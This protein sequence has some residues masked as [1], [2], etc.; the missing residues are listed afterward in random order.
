MQNTKKILLT[1]LLA[2][3]CLT[4]AASF[5]KP[6]KAAVPPACADEHGD[7]LCMVYNYTEQKVV[8]SYEKKAAKDKSREEANAR[9][10]SSL[11]GDNGGAYS[12]ITASSTFA[13]FSVI[14]K[15][16][17]NGCKFTFSPP[18]SAGQA[19]APKGYVITSEGVGE[20]SNDSCQS[21]G[22]SIIIK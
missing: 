16:G 3:L 20:T 19:T 12:V 14:Y 18:N 7:N 11:E 1:S 8:A 6:A 17:N 21:N 15:T 10:P 9:F 22:D 4:S 2:T 5:A 13:P